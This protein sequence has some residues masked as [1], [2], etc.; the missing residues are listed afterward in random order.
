MKVVEGFQTKLAHV[1]AEG[2]CMKLLSELDLTSIRLSEA[3]SVWDAYITSHSDLEDSVVSFNN[4]LS[5]QKFKFQPPSNIENCQQNLQ[6]LQ[7]MNTF[8]YLK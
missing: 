8:H 4:W 1:D 5:K 3:V 6:N 7:V 2:L